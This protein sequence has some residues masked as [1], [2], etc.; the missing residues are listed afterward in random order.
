MS[1]AGRH[2]HDGS[3]HARVVEF[4]RLGGPEVLRVVEREIPPPGPNEV[5]VA[6][7]AAGLNRAE[8]LFVAGHYLVEPVLPSRLGLEAAGTVDAVGAGVAGLKIGQHVAI[9]PSLD[10]ATHGVIG[11]FAV[12]PASAV[13]PAPVGLDAAEVA[14]LWM[15]YATAWGGLVRA[16]G[17]QAGDA[18]NVLVSAASS[19]VGL[20]AITVAKTYGARV[21]AT[22]RTDAKRAALDASG[23]D[24][25]LATDAGDL[26]QRIDA[27]TD[28]HGIDLAFDPINGAFIETLARCAARDGRIITYGLLAGETAPLPFREMIGKGLAIRSFHLGADLLGRPGPAHE[29]L[30]TLMPRFEDGSYRAT[31]DRRFPLERVAEAYAWLA[32]NEQVGKIVIEVTA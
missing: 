19:S 10:P 28:G 20:A 6:V 25:V 8:L 2:G 17:L 26:E 29:A 27:L 24:H 18:S 11:D 31:I 22:T 23:A 4:D 7:Q 13:H 3:R 32:G 15:A 16:G 30:T 1:G 21:I 14:A 12:V 9:L 5:R